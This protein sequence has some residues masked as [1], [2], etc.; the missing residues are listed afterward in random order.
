V[1]KE[2]E[3]DEDEEEEE[4]KEKEEG[5]VKGESVKLTVLSQNKI[6]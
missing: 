4:E 3:L 5:S 1:V 6:N 2:K